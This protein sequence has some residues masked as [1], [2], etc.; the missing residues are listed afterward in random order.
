M[1]DVEE[2]DDLRFAAGKAGNW[3][4]I[5]SSLHGVAVSHGTERHSNALGA[6]GR[7]SG[8]D[9]VNRRA[10]GRNTA[11]R[12]AAARCAAGRHVVGFRGCWANVGVGEG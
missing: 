11:T 12:C 5:D 10:A 3:D 7:G 4:A 8:R 6:G 2:L 1:V 9:A